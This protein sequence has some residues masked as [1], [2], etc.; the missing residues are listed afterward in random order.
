VTYVDARTNVWESRRRRA[1]DLAERKPHVSELL[2]F[3][4]DLLDIQE[5][6]YHDAASGRHRGVSKRPA[7]PAAWLD[8]L[9]GDALADPFRTFASAVGRSATDIIE[10]AAGAVS[11]ARTDTLSRLLSTYGARGDLAAVAAEF[12]CAIEPIAFLARA[13]VMPLVEA[14]R[15]RYASEPVSVDPRSCPSCGAKPQACIIVDRAEVKGQRRLVCSLCDASWPFPRASCPACGTH[16]AESLL[17]HSAET[18]KHGRVEECKRCRTYIKSFDL[19]ID[20]ATVAVVDDIA[21][22]ELDLW[23][24]EQNLTK[25]ATNPLGL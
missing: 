10:A 9:D 19:R 3:Y 25:I 24:T 1:H 5:P 15:V 12:D 23:A 2:G 22:V 16:D 4:L 20:G 18:V 11:I 7:S 8:Q 17:Y 14:V 6:V 21:S 13:F